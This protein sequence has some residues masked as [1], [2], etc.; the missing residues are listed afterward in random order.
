M[1]SFLLV[2]WL[3][4]AFTKIN[5]RQIIAEIPWG[6]IITTIPGHAVYNEQN[7]IKE[8]FYSSN[9]ALIVVLS[10]VK[11]QRWLVCVYVQR[12]QAGKKH[13]LQHLEWGEEFVFPTILKTP[14]YTV[15]EVVVLDC[16]AVKYS[17]ANHIPMS[18]KYISSILMQNHCHCR[19]QL[20]VFSPSEH[21][22]TTWLGAVWMQSQWANEMSRAAGKHLKIIPRLTDLRTVPYSEG[23][24]SRRRD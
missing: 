13:K 11:L 4:R 18:C 17:L 24:E 16:S 22:G 20:T 21:N 23:A 3:L 5:I 15:G 19:S 10:H 9:L 12:S 14:L 7:E 2:Q 6:F 1:W 8:Y